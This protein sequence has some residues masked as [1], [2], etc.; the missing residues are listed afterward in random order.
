M[1]ARLRGYGLLR[2]MRVVVILPHGSGIAVD[3]ASTVKVYVYGIQ[4]C[5]ISILCAIINII[6][7]W[8]H[9]K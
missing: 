9:M 1:T 7:I 5:K 3:V 2:I 8:Y 4:C 6:N